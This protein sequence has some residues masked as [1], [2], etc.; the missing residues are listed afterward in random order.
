M[1]GLIPWQSLEHGIR[2]FHPKAGRGRHPSSTKRP[3]TAACASSNRTVANLPTE[4]HWRNPSTMEYV[5]SGLEALRDTL[6]RDGYSSVVVPALGAGLGGHDWK[7]V[8]P[9]IREMLDI[10]GLT[11]E[12]H[13]PR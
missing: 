9:L 1:D 7:R 13:P 2:T 11:V 4:D 3:T 10:D 6:G 5:R 12:I 8:E